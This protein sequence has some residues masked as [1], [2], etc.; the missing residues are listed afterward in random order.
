MVPRNPDWLNSIST[1]ALASVGLPGAPYAATLYDLLAPYRT[2]IVVS[3]LGI[4]C[5]GAVTHF[6]GMLATRLGRFDDA[7]TCFEEA[8]AAEERL[9]APAWCAYTRYEQA[10][11]YLTRRAP[12]DEARAAALVAAARPVAEAHGMR[13]LVEVI[14]ALDV[15]AHAAAV[16]PV[17]SRPATA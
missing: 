15:A 3:G 6:L 2:R 12:G 5:L 17:P 9:E 10:V 7:A 11:L 1:L 8:I 14:D 4:L 13:R 16:E